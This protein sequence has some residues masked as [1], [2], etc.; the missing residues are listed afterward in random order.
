MDAPL[1]EIPYMRTNRLGA[2]DAR[3]RSATHG[4]SA[5]I[6]RTCR[7]ECGRPLFF[8][9]SVCLSCGAQVGYEPELGCLT[10]LAA[11]PAPDLW[12]IP[13]G[14]GSQRKSYRR[15]RNLDSPAGCNWVFPAKES[16]AENILCISCRLNRTIPNLAHA[17]NAE[18]WRRIELAK[19]RLISSLL[20]FGLPVA[21]RVSEDRECGV[22]FDL[23]RA[24]GNGTPVLTGHCEGIITLNIEEADDP[25]REQIRERMNEPYRTLLGHLRH[26]TGHYYW[27]RLVDRSD[28]LGG[29]REIFGDETRD[30]TAALERHY[31]QGPPP[32]WTQ[33]Y[34]SAYASV[35]PWEDWAETW[36]HYLHM[37]DTLGTASRFRLVMD[38]LELPFEGFESDSLRRP[39]EPN[40]E[41]FLQLLNFWGRTTVVLNEL[42]RSMGLADFY[43]FVL[44]RDAVAKLHFVHTIIESTA[45]SA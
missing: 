39:T 9:N 38:S 40:G 13:Y 20:A 42:S 15:C 30:Y 2:S 29:F 43:P 33:H 21:S 17:D 16:Q 4:L 6:S 45:E 31:Q 34:V 35:H 25:T 22:A 32:D 37:A 27:D 8:Q 23:L 41:A 24:P 44:S 36:A 18:Y 28:W 12:L 5:Q 10:L 11:G 26:E 3:P 14:S 7:C 19:R 1:L